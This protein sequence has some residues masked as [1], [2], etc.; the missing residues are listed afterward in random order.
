MRSAGEKNLRVV[1]T[2]R[3]G[4]EVLKI[5]ADEIP[6]PGSGQV[7]VKNLASGV[8]YAD[9]LMRHGLYPKAP[10]FPFAPGY[11]IVG[12]IDAVGEGVRGFSI[13]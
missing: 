7:R 10:P 9:V 8:A 3:G 13:G 1:I 11:D 6:E 12:D 2:R 4:P 5:V